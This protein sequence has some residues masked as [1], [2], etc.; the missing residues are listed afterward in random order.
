M[1]TKK[2]HLLDA[3]LQA[4]VNRLLSQTG[5][6]ESDF[7]WQEQQSEVASNQAITALVHTASSAC[8]LF[9]FRAHHHHAVFRRSGEAPFEAVRTE[10]WGRQFTE[11]R[12]WLGQMKET[13]DSPIPA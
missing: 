7:A 5:L 6:N 1:S 11:V 12:T 13:L 2:K 10:S 9:D 8:F 4:N 3:G